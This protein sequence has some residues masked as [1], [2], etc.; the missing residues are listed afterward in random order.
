MVRG[1]DFR[2]RG[3]SRPRPL[4]GGRPARWLGGDNCLGGQSVQTDSAHELGASC[5]TAFG[6]LPAHRPGRAADRAFWS[7]CCSPG[8]GSGSAQLRRAPPAAIAAAALLGCAMESANCVAIS[9]RD[10]RHSLLVSKDM[11]RVPYHIATRFRV[12]GIY[13]RCARKAAGC[14]CMRACVGAGGTKGC[15]VRFHRRRKIDAGVG[16]AVAGPG[17]SS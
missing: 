1:H 8:T 10:G 15:G 13:H 17:V 5:G 4:S 2:L 7:R 9:V 16:I 3:P 12:S 14:P 11:L 6:D